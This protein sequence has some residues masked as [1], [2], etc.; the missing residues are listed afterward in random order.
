MFKLGPHW[1]LKYMKQQNLKSLFQ[2]L[3]NCI[4]ANNFQA[5]PALQ[6]RI[7]RCETKSNATEGYADKK[8]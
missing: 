5:N 7:K 4:A 1:F 6:Q 2:D 8:K 3:K